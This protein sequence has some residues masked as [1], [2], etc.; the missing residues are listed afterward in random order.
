MLWALQSMSQYGLQ[1]KLFYLNTETG[2]FRELKNQKMVCKE[3]YADNLHRVGN[4]L[5][6]IGKTGILM[7]LIVKR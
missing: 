6:F 3:D 7:C 2:L 4:K 5:Y 1:L